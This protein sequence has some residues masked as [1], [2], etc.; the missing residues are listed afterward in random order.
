MDAE[1]SV[2]HVLGDF[3]TSERDRN[4]RQLMLAFLTQL[5]DTP[6]VLKGGTALYLAYGLNRFSEDLDFDSSARLNL[7]NRLK[8]VQ[9]PGFRILDL[10]LKKDTSYV[11]RYLVHYENSLH[12]AE[13]LKLEISYRTPVPESQVFV[14]DGLRFAPLARIADNKLTAAFDGDRIRSKGRD[15]FD[16]H[17]IATHYPDVLTSELRARLYG[18]AHDA[19]RVASRYRQDVAMDALLKAI[20]DVDLIAL[21]LADIAEQLVQR[22]AMAY[23][24]QN[25]RDFYVSPNFN[26]AAKLPDFEKTKRSQPVAVNPDALKNYLP[27][28]TSASDVSPESSSSPQPPRLK[29]PSM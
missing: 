20:M 12:Q 15:L 8:Q 10:N 17:F 28:D 6:L 21:E 23:G 2:N 29:P 7:T 4:H 5:S 25:P 14:H 11:T 22:D 16:L 19:E 3:I 1:Q 18:F 13:V 9:L 24:D 26:G 27:S